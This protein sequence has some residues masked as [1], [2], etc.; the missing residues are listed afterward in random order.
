MSASTSRSPACSPRAWWCTR[1][2]A[3]QNGEWVTPAEVKIEGAGDT[4]AR[5]ADRDRRA[6]RDRRH[7]EDVEVE[8]QHRRPRRHH[9]RPTAPTSRAGSCC[10]TRRPSATSNGP[11]AACRAPG[12]S[13]AAVA[14]DRR[15]RRDRRERAGRAARR[16]SAS[17]RWRCARPRMARSPRS[18]TRSRSCTSTSASRT[19]TNSPTRSA[20]RIGQARRHA[21]FRLGGARGR[22]HPGAAVPPDDA[23]PGRGVLGRARPRHP[24]RRRALADGRAGRCWS[25]T[26][27]T[28]P[29]QVNGKKR[30]DVTVPRDA[31]NAEIEAAVL[32]LDAVQQAL[33]GK[34]PKKVI[35]VPQRIVNVV[36]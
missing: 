8:A 11:R 7:R 22:R 1:P 28:L 18:P 24:G 26:R 6:G 33:D 31:T 32:A 23:A 19:S 10:R 30:A 17:R 12:A 29:V 34:R 14:A 3:R 21:R 5:D 25:R 13:S 2:I 36:A 9:R 20:R 35:V 27:I 16:S 15:G 4:R